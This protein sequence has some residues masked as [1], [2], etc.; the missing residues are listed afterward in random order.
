MRL[1]PDK[2]E[3]VV[4]LTVCLIALAFAAYTDHVWEDYW[5]TFRVSRNLATGQGAVYTVG[6]RV[7]AFTSPLGMLI[8]AGLSWV[9]GNKSDEL[10]IWL[11]RFVSITALATAAVLLLRVAARLHRHLLAT[12]LTL[13]LFALDSKTLDFTINGMETGLM[14]FFLAVTLHSLILGGPARALRTGIGWA[15]LMW[16]RPDGF[17]YIGA[18]ALGAMIFLPDTTAGA[19]RKDRMK[20]LFRAGLICTALYLPWLAWAWWY[21]GSPIPHT[22]IAKGL[23]LSDV[24]SSKF[25][26]DALLFPFA[27]IVRSPAPWGVFMPGPWH[28]TLQATAL[29]LAL[30]ASLAWVIPVLRSETRMLSLAFYIGLLYLTMIANEGIAHWYYPPFAALGYMTIGFLF[31]QLLSLVGRLPELQWERGWFRHL[32]SI[33]SITAV[34][35]IAAQALVN[36]CVA[37]QMMVQQILIENGIRKKIG[38]WLRDHAGSQKDRVFLEPLGYIGYF[39]QLKM[40]DWPG[41]ASREIIEARRRL[42]RDKQ[43]RAYLEVKPDW[44]VLRPWEAA[45]RTSFV[46]P[47]RLGE[48]YD[49]VAVFDASEQVRAVGWVPGRNYLE[50]DQTFFVYHRKLPPR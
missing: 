13:G 17:I 31:D 30:V 9:T 27:L 2:S 38:L 14:I 10:V 37:R 44:L 29:M 26:V 16:T 32:R 1:A 12:I 6:E 40:L 15:G 19:Q 7:H 11:F 28:Y 46:D 47:F 35:L 50:F 42:G 41:L 20:S 3:R 48:S 34:V 24:P 18:L 49:R 25:V 36:V 39:S 8:P 5:I 43:N 22:I 33:L 23:N 4:F 45:G 21:Y